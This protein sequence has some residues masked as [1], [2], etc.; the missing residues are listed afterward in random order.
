LPATPASRGH[1]EAGKLAQQIRDGRKLAA[2]KLGPR[3]DSRRDAGLFG[4]GF[5]PSGTD[6]DALDH[7]RD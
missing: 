6:N 3:Q 2:G 5:V 7:A 4:G 1:L